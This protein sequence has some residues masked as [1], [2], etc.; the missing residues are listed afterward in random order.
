MANA[1]QSFREFEQ[2]GWEDSAVV[3]KYHRHLSDVT[4]QS[5][6]A[7]LE[8]TAV[9]NG[10]RVLDVAT[11]AGYV[12]GAAAQR[13]ADA[14]G[15]DFSASQVR[16]ARERYPTVRF[17]Q[18]DAETLPFDSGT[19]D[20]VVCAFGMCHFPQSS[21]RPRGGVPRSEAWRSCGI[22]GMGYPGTLRR[23]RGGIRGDS[24]TW[25]DGRWS[26]CG[27]EFLFVQR[28]RSV[29]EGSPECGLYLAILPSGAPGVAGIRPGRDL[30]N[31]DRGNGARG[32]NA[33][34]AKCQRE[35]RDQS[36]DAGDCDGLQTR[37]I[38]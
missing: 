8:A 26:T 23:I 11:G 38:L 34:R 25:L 15:I 27:P 13:G 9:R 4:N 36:G 16:M 33:S 6:D 24:R 22:H 1:D 30:R 7:L 19:F 20:A 21:T 28:S 10:S 18:A 5:I 35:R 17:E 14:T 29:Y 37:R 3:A 12:A 31:G 32:G 2:A